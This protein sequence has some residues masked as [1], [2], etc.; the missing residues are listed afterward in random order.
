MHLLSLYSSTLLAAGAWFVTAPGWWLLCSSH[1]CGSLIP[2][3]HPLPCNSSGSATLTEPWLTAARDWRQWNLPIFSL[4]CQFP[5]DHWFLILTYLESS[6]HTGITWRVWKEDADAWVL[7]PE[8][9]LIGLGCGRAI[10]NFQSSWGS[11]PTQIAQTSPNPGNP[12][13]HPSQ[14][15]GPVLVYGLLG[16]RMHSRENCLPQTLSLVSERLGT[17]ALTSPLGEVEESWCPSA[18]QRWLWK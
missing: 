12:N 3:V 4:G 17:T 8:S 7:L 18:A 6:N 14:G 16:A 1:D 11:P 10:E 2:T 15:C 13:H 9:D 5:Q